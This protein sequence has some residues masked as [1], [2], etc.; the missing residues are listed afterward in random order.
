MP[1]LEGIEVV[2]ALAAY[3]LFMH[4]GRWPQA[5]GVLSEALPKPLT[6]LQIEPLSQLR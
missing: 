2:A 3:E 4:S 1:P 5:G 6:G